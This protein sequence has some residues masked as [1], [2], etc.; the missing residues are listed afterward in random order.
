MD[1]Q[2]S[3]IE[4][5]MKNQLLSQNMGLTELIRFYKLI[6][7]NHHKQTFTIPKKGCK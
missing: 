3:K 5:S 2:E 1:T 7:T 4:P 6:T